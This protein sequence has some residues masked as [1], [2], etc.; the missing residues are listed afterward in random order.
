MMISFQLKKRNQALQKN[1]MNKKSRCIL[2]TSDYAME[3]ES[4]PNDTSQKKLTFFLQSWLNPLLIIAL[5]WLVNDKL[6]AMETKLAMIPNLDKQLLT[7]DKNREVLSI[8][9]DILAQKL[10]ELTIDYKEHIKQVGTKEETF[11]IPHRTNR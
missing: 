8:R 9:V 5:G 2:L 6:Q 11:R 3:K 4:T 1:R 10:D 7:I